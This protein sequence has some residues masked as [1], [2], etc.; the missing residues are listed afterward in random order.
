MTTAICLGCIT[1]FPIKPFNKFESVIVFIYY[2]KRMLQKDELEIQDHKFNDGIEKSLFKLIEESPIIIKC[3]GQRTT[4]KEYALIAREK[5]LNTIVEEFKR[6]KTQES[7]L[8]KNEQN[9]NKENF[10]NKTHT[11]LERLRN[12]LQEINEENNEIID[13]QSCIYMS[14][15]LS[16]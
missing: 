6:N 4:I 14:D 9:I 8:L 2:V 15:Y 1:V 12:I 10:T 7:G 16:N 3:K 5:K 11:N 13:F